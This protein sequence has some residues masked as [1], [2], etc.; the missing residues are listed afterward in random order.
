MRQSAF[1]WPPTRLPARET[2]EPRSSTQVEP[3]T[4][5]SSGTSSAPGIRATEGG[6]GV[7]CAVLSC[8][9]LPP[10]GVCRSSVPLVFQ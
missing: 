3:D 2:C 5:Y 7:F 1:S 8:L 10:C 6:A 4:Q 9:S